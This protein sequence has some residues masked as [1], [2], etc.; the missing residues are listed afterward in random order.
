MQG[1][2]NSSLNTAKLKNFQFGIDCV[3]L[4]DGKREEIKNKFYYFRCQLGMG[5]FRT[6]LPMAAHHSSQYT[7]RT[8]NAYP[9]QT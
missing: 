3:C 9:T 7:S 6:V 5:D 8:H 1:Y 4:M 2:Q